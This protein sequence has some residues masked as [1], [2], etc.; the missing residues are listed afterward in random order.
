[1]ELKRHWELH[2]LH[3]AIEHERNWKPAKPAALKKVMAYLHGIEKPR[4]ETLD[5]LSLFVGFQDWD[6]FQRALHGE[7]SANENYEAKKSAPT[8]KESEK[9]VK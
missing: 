1:M 8:L 3:E 7:A 6:S 2:K 9:S 5:R 4:K